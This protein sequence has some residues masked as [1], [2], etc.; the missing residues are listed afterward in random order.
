ML[1]TRRDHVTGPPAMR[2]ELEVVF[3]ID[4][5]AEV[6]ML[7]TPESV[8]PAGAGSVDDD[9]TEAVFEMIDVVSDGIENPIDS[10]TDALAATVPSAQDTTP[11]ASLHEL[12]DSDGLNVRPAGTLSV[13]TTDAASDGPALVTVSGNTAVSPATPEVSPLSI[14]R[15]DT[16]VTV[17]DADALLFDATGSLPLEVTVTLLVRVEPLAI[18]GDTVA[19]TEAANVAPTASD[20]AEHVSVGRSQV[21][22]GVLV[23]IDVAVIPT[24]SASV[25]TT[26]SPA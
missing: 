12:D 23:V 9:E 2:A 22:P 13:T 7:S 10:G 14:D 4:M 1:V 11:A 15:S 18:D 26:F 25:N 16:R 6:E 21:A 17:S 20:G 5:S 3:E 19:V 8:L 24:G